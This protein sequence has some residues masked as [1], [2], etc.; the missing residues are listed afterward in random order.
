M[1]TVSIGDTHGKAIADVVLEII[2]EHD[3]FI[4]MGDY[5]DNPDTGNLPIKNN[6]LAIIALKKRYPEK[7]I[8]LWGNHDIQYLLDNEYYCSGYRPGMKKGLHK[9]FSLNAELFQLAYQ[10][11][12]YLWT[13]A[14]VNALWFKN[15]FKPF[16]EDHLNES[17]LSELLNISFA[18]RFKPLFD[19][20][21]LRG[22]YCKAGGPL[23]CDIEELKDDQWMGLNQI[24]WHN[25][26]D[27][28]ERIQMN[29][30]EVIFIDILDNAETIDSSCFFY[31]EI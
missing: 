1:K 6:L 2:N 8:L 20:G 15:R 16:A 27:Q 18:E 17:S 3:K 25:R 28:I 4:F 11:G 13:H 14:G 23:W 5:V 19:I 7:I 12:D 29:G 21:Y 30:N 22:G 26:V 24:A 9:I 31:K 10:S